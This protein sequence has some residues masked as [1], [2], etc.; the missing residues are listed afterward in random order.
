MLIEWSGPELNW[1]HTDFQSVALPTELP[2]RPARETPGF[3]EQHS[4]YTRSARRQACFDRPVELSI[5]VM[6]APAKYEIYG[7]PRTRSR[8]APACRPPQ[9]A[10]RRST[11]RLQASCVRF[12]SR[13]TSRRQHAERACYDPRSAEPVF[14]FR[15]RKTSFVSIAASRFGAAVYGMATTDFRLRRQRTTGVG[16]ENPGRLAG[17]AP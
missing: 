8:H 15:R 10:S 14:G 12:D 2:D 6:S 5:H 9:R 1:R 3:H 17:G 4:V 16:A 13:A 11:L 7:E